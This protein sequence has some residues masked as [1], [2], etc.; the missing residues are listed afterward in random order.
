MHTDRVSRIPPSHGR[1]A[2][3][4]ARPE[5]AGAR[6]ERL[7]PRLL[8][9][10]DLP[11]LVV[12]NFVVPDQALLPGA[13]ASFAI[14][15]HNAG[16]VP[17]AGGYDIRLLLTS[18]ITPDAFAVFDG[19]DLHLLAGAP[20]PSTHFDPIPFGDP[21]PF[22]QVLAPGETA[23]VNVDLPVPELPGLYGPITVFGAV[24][25]PAVIAESDG[26]NNTFRSTV[27][28]DELVAFDPRARTRRVRFLTAAGNRMTVSLSNVTDA[29]VVLRRYA[30]D[31]LDIRAISFAGGTTRSHLRVSGAGSIGAIEGD[32]LQALSGSGRLDLD[33]DVTL[34]ALQRMRVGDIADGVVVNVTRPADRGMHIQAEYIGADVAFMLPGR[35]RTFRAL[36]YDGGLLAVD[37]LDRFDLRGQRRRQLPGDLRATLEISGDGATRHA[38]GT[39]RI[40]GSVVDAL[41]D[42]DGPHGIGQL[43]IDGD[44][45]NSVVRIDV[46]E[47]VIRPAAAADFD[48]AGAG[49]ADLRLRGRLAGSDVFAPLLRR[50]RLGP[51]QPDNQSVAFGLVALEVGSVT[52]ASIGRLG[53]PL[54]PGA[55][56][57]EGDYA[58]KVLG[59]L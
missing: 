46:A 36:Q 17:A 41:L 30:G 1:I 27:F 23:T 44:L 33:G 52:R 21:I 37:V 43:R 26:Q 48:S 22:D 29:R 59:L 11:D 7:E 19:P 47:G 3:G 25:D 24:N 15:V 45:L 18:A 39:G 56:D 54:T 58:F 10:G 32:V 9:A 16:P 2:T 5:P 53:P 50:V 34:D 49:I 55:I 28:A 51:V 13:G 4:R 40:R 57:L 6:F 14:D 31:T 8:L 35:V 12:T 20:A 42:V 38:L